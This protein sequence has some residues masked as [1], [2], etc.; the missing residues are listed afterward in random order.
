MCRGS[1]ILSCTSS[2]ISLAPSYW[3]YPGELLDLA[4]IGL[5]QLRKVLRKVPVEL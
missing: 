2:V 5:D 4:D 3:T 1:R